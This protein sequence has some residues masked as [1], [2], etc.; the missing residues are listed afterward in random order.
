VAQRDDFQCYAKSVGYDFEKKRGTLNMA[1]HECCDMS[2]CIAFFTKI[3]P[4]VKR[5]DTFSGAVPDT[6]YKRFG[7]KWL[8]ITP[9][10]LP[11]A[12]RISN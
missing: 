2:G 8:A 10:V 5:I 11:S 4:D 9:I 12:A 6:I 7:R 1:E 3:D